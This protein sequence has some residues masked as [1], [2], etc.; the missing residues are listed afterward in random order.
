MSL[1]EVLVFFSM[2][3]TTSHQMWNGILAKIYE[4]RTTNK[5]TVL[6]DC[7]DWKSI[8][9]NQSYQNGI[10]HVHSEKGETPSLAYARRDKG[11]T[12]NRLINVCVYV[13]C[14][15]RISVMPM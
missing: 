3:F 6:I 10:I 14:V 5:S 7:F 2:R 11:E 13:V 9:L 1:T 15:C 12:V 8:S 4:N